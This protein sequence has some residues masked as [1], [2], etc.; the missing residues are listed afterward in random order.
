MSRVIDRT[1]ASVRT[2]NIL[3]RDLSEFDVLVSGSV[4]IGLDLPDDS[5]YGTLRLRKN[6][7]EG[8]GEII[9]RRYL[10]DSKIRIVF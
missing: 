5:K 4:V 7:A 9:V 2:A 10:K 8:V 6:N 3:V 1:Y